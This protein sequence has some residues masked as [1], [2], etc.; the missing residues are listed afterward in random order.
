[1]TSDTTPRPISPLRARM[2][3]DMSVRGFKEDTRRDYVRHVRAFA[4]FIGRSQTSSI[5]IEPIGAAPMP[6]MWG[7]GQLQVMS[8]IEQ[9]RSAAL[10]GHV[11]CCEECGHSRIAYPRTFGDRKPGLLVDPPGQELGDPAV[12]IGVARR[13]DV[14]PGTAGRAATA[15]QVEELAR[16]EMRQLIEAAR[17]WL[18]P[19]TTFSHALHR[20]RSS[21][22]AGQRITPAVQH[23]SALPVR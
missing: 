13:S 19:K 16:G 7:L 17:L 5:A 18:L 12:R 21:A 3:E 15:D 23:E 14:G 8:A 2:I 4:A 22:V 6:D 20:G 1:M 9:C 11:E 10:G